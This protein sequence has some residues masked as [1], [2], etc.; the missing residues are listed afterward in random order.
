MARRPE[1]DAPPLRQQRGGT[2][3]EEVGV[4]GPEAHHRDVGA[5]P[6]HAQPL[7]GLAAAAA[8]PARFADE[9]NTSD[10]LGVSG[11]NTLAAT[12]TQIP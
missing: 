9:F 12:G 11:V 2:R 7:N 1:V 6:R 8:T 10:V 3:A 4:G 5:E